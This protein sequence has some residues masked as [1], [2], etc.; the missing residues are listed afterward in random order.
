MMKLKRELKRYIPKKDQYILLTIGIIE[1]IIFALMIFFSK[2]FIKPYSSEELFGA[3][4][5]LGDFI[6]YTMLCIAVFIPAF[7]CINR[8]EYTK[9]IILSLVS[10]ILFILAIY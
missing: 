5:R 3:L 7:Y 4:G 1:L 10:I 9:P 6:A 8:L 2:A